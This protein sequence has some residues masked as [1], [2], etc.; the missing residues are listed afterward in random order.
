MS[1]RQS[2]LSESLAP[3][4]ASESSGVTKLSISLSSDLVD[5]VRRTAEERGSTVSA[6]IAAALRKAQ[7]SEVPP[8]PEDLLRGLVPP[9]EWIGLV[10][11]AM[12]R[13]QALGDLLLEVVD[14]WLKAQGLLLDKD[15]ARRVY[16]EFR[17]AQDA[18]N[19]EHGWTDE[20]IQDL[21]DAEVKEFRAARRA[22]R[23]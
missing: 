12:I 17:A 15:E 6:T 5:E 21:V 8:T 1:K 11:L 2:R 9:R 4:L 22:R 14:P 13:E 20:Q 23:R 19:K 3:Y 10:G 7:D 16:A 18:Y